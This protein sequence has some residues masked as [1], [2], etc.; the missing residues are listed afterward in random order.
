MRELPELTQE[1]IARLAHISD[2]EVLQDIADTEA[3][4]AQVIML[5]PMIDDA[6]RARHLAV[7]DERYAFIAKLH[8]LLAA[9][10]ALNARQVSATES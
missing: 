1:T 7:N 3:E 9:R 4:I 8:A 6:A 10:S 5:S 2:A